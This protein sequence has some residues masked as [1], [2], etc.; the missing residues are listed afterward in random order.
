MKIRIGTRG[1]TLALWQAYFV[2]AALLKGEPDMDVE[3][4]RITT[5]GDMM[6]RARR[7]STTSTGIFTRAIELALIEEKVD[8]AVHSLKD[9]PTDLV[10]GLELGAVPRREDPADGLI[11]KGDKSL[12]E[13]P[14]GAIVLTGSPRRRSQLLGLRPDLEV[15]PVRG[16]VPTRID[17]MRRGSAHGI[18]LACAG[19][20]RLGMAHVASERLEPEKF[21]PAA[22]QGALAVEF[23]EDDATARR[24]CEA[25]DDPE[26]RLAVTAERAFMRSL[27]AGCRVPAG[28]LARRTE[29]AD[30]MR[31]IGVVGEPDGS[32]VLRGDV[33]RPVEDPAAAAA[34]G[35]ALADQL[36]DMGGEQILDA[37]RRAEQEQEGL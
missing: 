6:R 33:T 14:E 19:L 2:R 15:R 24:L 5:T 23:R 3:L 30:Q 28:A 22:A 20:G 21:V 32:R 26:S 17:K 7:A 34:L 11:A 36:R 25:I 31:I 37:I 27:R 13:L 8:V 16:N 9:L 4:V 1:S 35:R 29:P 12:N 10:E 18:V